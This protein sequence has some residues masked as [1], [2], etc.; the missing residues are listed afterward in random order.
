MKNEKDKLKELE[1]QKRELAPALAQS[2][3]K[4]LCL[5]ALIEGVEEHDTVDVKKTFGQRASKKSSSK[6]KKR[7]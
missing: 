5:E 6:F 3:L 7:S 1:H 4:N 2:Y